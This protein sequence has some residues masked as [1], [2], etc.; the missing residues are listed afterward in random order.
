MA[1]GRHVDRAQPWP[2]GSDR[3][4]AIA[5]SKVADLTRD[6]RGRDRLAGEL[7]RW[8]A[9]WWDRSC[10]VGSSPMR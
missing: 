5:R 1:V 10:R 2:D 7:A 3:V 9:R 8:A 4:L 6:E